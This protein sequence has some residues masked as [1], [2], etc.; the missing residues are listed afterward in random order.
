[1]ET[2]ARAEFSPERHRQLRTA[3]M[4]A[5]GA[6]LL[7]VLIVWMGWG[8]VRDE[9]WDAGLKLMAGVMAVLFLAAQGIALLIALAAST[10]VRDDEP[11]LV[12]SAVGVPAVALVAGVLALI[13][14]G[15]A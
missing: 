3:L 11:R 15:A 2:P 12:R 10:H 14:L 9:G 5:G 13:A 1:M 7:A 8:I 6:W 4:V